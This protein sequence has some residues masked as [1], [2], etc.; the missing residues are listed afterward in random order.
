MTIFININ[1]IDGEIDEYCFFII[2][3]FYQVM[4]KKKTLS[5]LS[6]LNS[7]QVWLF[8]NFFNLHFFWS[9]SKNFP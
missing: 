7:L 5:N 3:K 4:F 6:N 8:L 9:K 2:E 1:Q